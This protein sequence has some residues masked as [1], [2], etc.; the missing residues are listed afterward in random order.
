MKDLITTIQEGIFD[1][2]D[3]TVIDKKSD[4][5]REL[6][7]LLSAMKAQEKGFDRDCLGNKLNKGDY[8]L[9]LPASRGSGKELQLGEITAL[10]RILTVQI[11]L[12]RVMA[13][14]NQCVKVTKDMVL[15]RY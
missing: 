4:N 6:G 11:E 10:G 13:H 9:F 7:I 2:T 1:M 12:G 14:S 3:D 8:V 15:N 5:V